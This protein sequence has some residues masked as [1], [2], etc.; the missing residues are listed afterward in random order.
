MFLQECLI[1]Q[2]RV[3]LHVHVCIYM[4]F[5]TLQN[6][7][8]CLYSNSIPIQ[9]VLIVPPGCVHYDNKCKYKSTSIYRCLLC[10]FYSETNQM[11]VLYIAII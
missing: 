9:N 7:Q 3:Y 4:T 2:F 10:K 8:P 11:F 5:C 6:K 1:A